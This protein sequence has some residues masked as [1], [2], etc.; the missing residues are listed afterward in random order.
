MAKSLK[1]LGNNTKDK[2]SNSKFIKKKGKVY[3]N[4]SSVL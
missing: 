2:I 3:I 4:F 1:T